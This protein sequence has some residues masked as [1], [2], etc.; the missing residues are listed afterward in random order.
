MMN[1]HYQTQLPSGTLHRFEDE[2]DAC[3]VG[4]VAQVDG[5][6]SHQIVKYGVES[7]CNVT[8]R[9]A[10]DADGK[11][12][13]GA[14]VSTQIP[15][16]LFKPEL[17]KLGVTLEDPSA[18]GIGMFFLP[19]EDGAQQ[20]K[21]KV[22]AEGVL[23]NRGVAVYGWRE[24]PVNPKELGDTALASRPDILQLMIGRPDGESS[25]AFERT[26]FL[27]RREIEIKAQQ[28]GITPF[29]I[30]SLSARL[31]SYKG[32]M[33]ASA[34]DNFYG[35]LCNPDFESAICLY[36]QRFS[37]NTFPTW[38]LGQPFRMLAH[39]GEINTLRGN[40]NWFNSRASDFA[41]EVDCWT[42][43]DVPLF[44]DLLD[45]DAS[46]SASLDGALELLVLSGR[47]VE[48]SMAMLVPPAWR[49][50]PYT[51]EEEKAFYQY[52]RCF[53]EPWDGPAALA[54][55]DGLTVAAS[56]DRNGLRPM[57]FKHT[58]D[59]IFT[60]GSEVGVIH[61]DDAKVIAKG[62]LAP[63]E[64]LSVNT[65]TGEVQYN[66]EI[67]E[68]LAKSQ[69]YGEWLKN[70][71]NLDDEVSADPEPGAA[72]GIDP[73]SRWQSQTANGYT[74]EELNMSI[75][76]MIAAGQEATYSM[77]DDTP[78][79]VLSYQPRLLYTYFKQLFAQVTN[80]PI[81]P[82]RERLVMSISADLGPEGNLLTETPGH[83][84]VIHLESPFLFP[85]QLAALKTLNSEY[86]TAELD[87]TWPVSEGAAGLKKA[88]DALRAAAEKACDDGVKLIVLT[89]KAA[90]H[91]RAAMPSLVATGAVHQHLIRSE[92]RMDVS[93][94]L[95]SAEPR[96]THQMA[97]LFG[98]GV[99]A[100]CPY[101]AFQTIGEI[102]EKDQTVRK[103]KLSA[104]TDITQGLKNYRS[105]LEKGVL[106]IMSKMGIS[107]LNSYQ[108]AQ[109]FEAIGLS[110]NFIGECFDGTPS[111]I[112]GIDFADVAMETLARHQA[113][114]GAAVPE[115]VSKLKLGDP[116]NYRWRRNGEIHAIANPML[117]NFH[118]FV[119]ENDPDKYEKYLEDV[120]A[121]RPISLHDMWEFVPSGNA[122][123][124]EDVEPI[125]DIRVRFTTA[126]MSLGAL[127]P[128][129]HETLA[130]AMNRIGGKSDSGEGGE[131]AERFNSER[132]SKIKQV[133]SGRFGVHAEYL[134]SADE[135]EIKM[136][137]GAK[138]GEGGQLPGHKV[139][140]II[141]KLRHT[142]PGVTLISPPPH[143]D[144]YSIE[145]LAQL[146]HDLKEVNPRARV[147]VKLVAET[148]VGTIA[149]GV[150][151]A[152]A[153]II[154][155]SGHDGGTGAS[156][157][158]SIR[159]AGLPWELGVAETQQV[160]MMNGL[161]DR[162]T[163]RTDGGMR[164]GRDIIT[165]AILGAEE[166]NF[167]TIAMIAMGCVYVRQCH[168]N[169]CP[170][171]IATQQEHLRAKFKGDPEHVINFFNAVA[172]EAREIMAE[173]GVSKLN[174]LIGRPE[175]LKV[176]EIEDHPK[177]NKLDFSKL[178]KDVAAEDGENYPRYCRNLRNDGNHARPLDDKILQDARLAI[179]D[180]TP[181]E[182]SYKVKNTNRNVGTKLAGE[183]AYH[184]GN[185]GLPDGT[186]N[187]NLR[188][189]AGQSFATF[190]CGGVSLI[191][192]GEAND[193]VGKGMCG[194]EIIIKPPTNRGFTPHENSIIGNTVMYG[195]TGGHLFANGR[196]GERLCVRNSGG[197]AIVEG[198]G[199]H[200]CE[201]MTN[202][203]VFILGP[204][205]KNFG[206]GMSGGLAYIYDE[207]GN[208]EK[209]YNP[210]MV[211]AKALDGE[212]DEK[213]L[214]SYIYQHI[215]KTDSE[216]AKAIMA[217][218][219]SAKAKFVKVV[220]KD[221]SVSAAKDE[222]P[223]TVAAK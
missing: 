91:A 64:M 217:D 199:D 132:N 169:T 6:A 121:N 191:L 93:L 108:G 104:V 24:V 37:T 25:E 80:P 179:R 44:K 148:G 53:S 139:S 110:E 137:Q 20:L 215:E 95:E 51:S 87:I 79:S 71:I 142:Q 196:A 222:K 60:V 52:H 86:T 178:L 209:L 198:C 81:D 216:R 85:H 134:A 43:K 143:H 107:V 63:G 10:V 32:L 223:K 130:I 124:V 66:N 180:K 96:D 57:R 75:T 205:G 100:I 21:A 69:P 4:F 118:T 133:A 126:A 19:R 177:A 189:S 140:G 171:G 77:G 48:H 207:E 50:D 182:L 122:I 119:R 98:Y 83:A 219:A 67:K 59:G 70:R 78:L 168:L 11:T 111:Q 65:V 159:H 144:I 193:Y 15:F 185:H 167:G 56:L 102:F 154:L 187:V 73:L 152:N 35:D 131:S 186:I 136:A 109:I 174:D 117:K 176:R 173:L 161:R 197:T 135:I 218:W 45:P 203:L 97:C 146:I 103:P 147:C 194:G 88:V 183:I 153:D 17:D 150:A 112:D 115:D 105:A 157:L 36:H 214:Q 92:K 47:S 125:E 22:L 49:I 120:L 158:S 149:A 114:Y 27:A 151:K 62:R 41:S 116:G 213:F 12:G 28:E 204:T 155:V 55:S 190:L 145:D 160:L 94:I 8:H 1:R 211:E 3:G 34:L 200:G 72:N 192:T 172:N 99:T 128:E 175:L 141:A 84:R 165:A 163:L 9:G 138:P 7:V 16:K 166:F 123:P 184:H 29:Y 181:V 5:V 127:S 38:S 195:S 61:L 13:D 89:D 42:E 18:L 162:V 129:A 221:S 113:A 208:F 188:G 26:L 40:R 23:R 46:D 74:D 106:K 206:A 82:I 202:G 76:P 54:F 39:N 14:G 30:A 220:P 210:E 212:E 2:H 170:V 156:P 101:L 164:N 68:G 90:S 31:L 201:Y 33:V 58:S